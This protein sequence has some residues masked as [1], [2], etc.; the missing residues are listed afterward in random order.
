[1]TYKQAQ[2]LGVQVRAGKKSTRVV[3]TKKLRLPDWVMQNKLV[4][5]KA[6]LRH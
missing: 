1:M 3:F 4:P 2:D 5:H 6:G